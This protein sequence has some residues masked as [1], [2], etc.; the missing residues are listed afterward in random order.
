ML[1]MFTVVVSYN[2]S[3]LLLKICFNFYLYIKISKMFQTVYF[4]S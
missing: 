1:F 3:T 4:T 2:T